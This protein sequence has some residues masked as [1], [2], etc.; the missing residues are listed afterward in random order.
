MAGKAKAR[1]M[2]G[3]SL[4]IREAVVRATTEVLVEKGLAALSIAMIA[5]RAGVHPTSIYRRWKT[6]E[7][8][9]LDVALDAAA[10]HVQIP[11]TG[12]LR[13]DLIAFLTSLDVHIRSPLGRVLLAL[14]ALNDEPA[15]SAR[16]VF[17]R[18]RFSLAGVMFERAAMRGEV[19]PAIDAVFALEFA[20]APVYLRALVLQ[21]PH[22]K[23]A[24]NRHVDATLQ[25]VSGRVV[26][27]KPNADQQFDTQA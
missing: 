6:P 20:I 1:R 4:R 24:I 3:R 25:I 22:D 14:S 13:S 23:A 2:G 15:V 12:S 11:N 19:S 16:Q 8:L 5:D 21:L 17:W 27:G 7:R 10:V 26:G 18:Q 9:A